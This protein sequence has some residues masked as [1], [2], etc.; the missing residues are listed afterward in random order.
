[1]WHVREQGA[2]SRLSIEDR[3][4]SWCGAWAAT[5][6]RAA[7]MPACRRAGTPVA[8]VTTAW[9]APSCSLDLCLRS[10]VRPT[11]HPHAI[12]HWAVPRAALR[13]C[14]GPMAA[15]CASARDGHGWFCGAGST[16]G[17]IWR[18]LHAPPCAGPARDMTLPGVHRLQPSQQA[19]TGG[20]GPMA[21]ARTA[22]CVASP[23]TDCYSCDVLCD[24]SGERLKAAGPQQAGAAFYK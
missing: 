21:Q 10:A 19:M 13:P 7:G 9:H 17:Q 16:A 22:G 8:V 23:G 4:K 1:M 14:C 2:G 15:R 12:S 3:C 20:E 24:K 11:V 5:T 18:R 6:L